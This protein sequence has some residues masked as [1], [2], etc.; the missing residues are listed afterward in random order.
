MVS[1]Q[2]N[3][4]SS[5]ENQTIYAN[6]PLQTAKHTT[7]EQGL[8]DSGATHNFI[9]IQTII[10][11][12]IGT[13]KLKTPRTVTNVDGTT[14]RAGQIN[15]Y[16]YLLFEYNG[17]TKNLPV[18]V[19]NLGRD[20]IILGLPWFQ[21]LE[22]MIS[23]KQGKLLG[24]LTAKTSSKVLEINKTTLA[25]NWA[26]REETG[27]V[28]ISEK[29]IPK[30]YE[31]YSDVLSEEKAKRFPPAREDDHQ[32]KFTENVPKYF[33]ADVY[34]LTINQMAFLRKWLDKELDKGFIRPSKSPYPCPTFLIEKKNG[35]YRVVQNYKI[36]NEHT[37][38]DKHPLPL[39]TNLIEQLHRK[40][41]FTKFDI[42]MG[43][44][45]IRIADRDQE[46]AAF[47]TPLGQYEPM[48]MNFGL[49]NA[50]ATFV[51][52][53]TRI[54]RTLQNTYPGEVLIYMD[55]ILIATPNDLP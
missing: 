18:F 11:L 45:N 22:P 27:K 44:N 55:D 8:L 15:R 50:P 10:C 7:D 34:S 17:K 31:D 13:R 32:I 6:F 5:G 51:W 2:A 52:A 28:Q 46:K 54:F 9:N 48:V 30:Q 29:D 53:M 20:R 49:C 42:R 16:A 37:I 35:D 43:Y 36:L 41:L 33:K 38:P 4:V 23:W 26:I 39:I 40:T 25:T 24:D 3:N 14:N 47:T 19:T 1:M 12:G 21:E